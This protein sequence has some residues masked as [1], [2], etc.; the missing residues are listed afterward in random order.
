MLEILENFHKSLWKKEYYYI[1]LRALNLKQ[2]EV[3]SYRHKSSL[4]SDLLLEKVEYEHLTK[5]SNSISNHEALRFLNCDI[6]LT[7]QATVW[8]CRQWVIWSCYEV[9]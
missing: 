2:T 7:T 8:H 1:S 5:Q 4:L 9:A 6:N 3:K